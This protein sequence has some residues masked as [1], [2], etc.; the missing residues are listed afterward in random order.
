MGSM[1]YSA[2]VDER[3]ISFVL[4]YPELVNS[5]R[6]NPRSLTQFFEQIASID[7][8][9]GNLQLVEVLNF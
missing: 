1:A 6:T 4:T 9:K 3:G 5:E 7:D 8:L 2:N